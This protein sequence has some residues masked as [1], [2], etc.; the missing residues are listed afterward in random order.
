MRSLAKSFVAETVQ[1]GRSE[2]LRARRWTPLRRE[3]N[4]PP[5]R[6]QRVVVGPV[7]FQSRSSVVCGAEVRGSGS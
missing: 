4:W 1:G 6:A 5:Q 3:A 7:W 2:R